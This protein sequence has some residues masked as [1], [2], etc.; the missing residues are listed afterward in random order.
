M[1][2]FFLLQVQKSQPSCFWHGALFL[3]VLDIRM[4]LP[5]SYNLQ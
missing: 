1:C 3:A 2:I 4:M 5:E